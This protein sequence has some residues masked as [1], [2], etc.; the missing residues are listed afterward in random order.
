[1]DSALNKGSRGRTAF[2]GFS[3]SPDRLFCLLAAGLLFL[4]FSLP[5]QAADKPMTPLSKSDYPTRSVERPITL[6]R[7]WIEMTVG[8][9]ILGSDFFYD[10]REDKVSGDY[11]FR[12]TSLSLSGRYGF[13]RR[14]T[15][16]FTLPF[17]WKDF[18]NANGVDLTDDSIGDAFLSATYQLLGKSDPMPS[19]ALRVWSLVPSG[20]ESPGTVNNSGL[21]TLLTSWGTYSL[22]VALLG[23]QQIKCFSIEAEAGYVWRISGTVMFVQGIHGEAGHVNWGDKVYA[24]TGLS[25]QIPDALVP[26][27]SPIL[28][29][30]LAFPLHSFWGVEMAGINIGANAKYTWWGSSEAGIRDHLQEIPMSEGWL[31]EILPHLRLEITDHWDLDLRASV[32]LAGKNTNYAFPLE[33]AGISGVAELRLRF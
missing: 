3:P 32:P 6:S 9:S 30:Y 29:P 7:G 13:T 16:G 8:L 14:L 19:L 5:A 10:N 4:A 22:A 18:K 2:P 27:L 26:Y 11:E 25:H 23:K 28:F 17:V 31:L 1:M 33:A 15:L 21:K 20:N 12:M 24:R